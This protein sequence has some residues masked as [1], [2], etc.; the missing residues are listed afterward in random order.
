MRNALLVVALVVVALLALGAVPSYLGSGTSYHLVVEPTDDEG[1]AID[2]TDISEQRYPYLTAAL[3]ADDG[4]SD[5]YQRGLGGYKTLFAHSPFD[6]FEA[7][8]GLDPAATRD[9]GEQLVVVDD[10]QR[11][12]VVIMSD[13]G[14]D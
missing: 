2:V 11:Y 13:E 3:A 6:E 4:R 7:L 12:D 8:E 10:D 5:G 14:A 9:E 1:E